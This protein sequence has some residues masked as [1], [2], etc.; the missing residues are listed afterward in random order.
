MSGTRYIKD[1]KE[2]IERDAYQAEESKLINAVKTGNLSSVK[3]FIDNDFFINQKI[4][5]PGDRYDP[6]TK[7][8]LLHVAIIFKQFEIVKFLV[9]SGA[10]PLDVVVSQEIPLAMGGSYTEDI[11]VNFG[12]VAAFGNLDICNFL[13][14]KFNFSFI[15]KNQKFGEDE[16]YYFYPENMFDD[17]DPDFVDFIINNS[18]EFDI[19]FDKTH[20]PSKWYCNLFI[21]ACRSSI[22]AMKYMIEKYGYDINFTGCMYLRDPLYFILNDEDKEFA[23]QRMKFLFDNGYKF[24]QS[25]LEEYQKKLRNDRDSSKI[26]AFLEEQTPIPGSR[27]GPPIGNVLFNECCLII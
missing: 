20:C 4:I 22:Q 21:L 12:D 23:F 8:T 19:E 10:K 15:R 24:Y 2:W 3:E 1:L 6:K 5:T 18:S 7:F 26:L 13:I 9:D 25:D 17:F 11:D 14:L 16:C 27:P